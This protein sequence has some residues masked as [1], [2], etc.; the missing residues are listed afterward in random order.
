VKWVWEQGVGIRSAQGALLHLEGFITDIT[1]EMEAKVEL[2]EALRQKEFLMRELNHRVKNNLNMVSSLIN[3][4]DAESRDDLADIRAQINA[5][6]IIH[7][8]LNRTENLSEIRVRPY[9][10]E[11][12]DTVFTTFS[13]RTVTVENRVEDTVIKPE[14]ALPL[15]LIT[16]EAATNAIKHG[17]R[18]DEEALFTVEFTTLDDRLYEL[19]LS[20]SGNPFPEEIDIERA[21]TL[22][23][24][25]LR[26][27]AQQLDGSVE[28][29]KAPSP[30][31]TIRFPLETG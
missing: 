1:E 29:R 13:A 4:K 27:L 20:N 28:L 25:L 9:L 6:R 24:Q 26:T 12:L 19:R 16:N 2:E 15:G 30:M 22:G 17:F 11:L 21:E 10:E 14:V 3:L 5:I 31:F 8:K 18:E 23:L 7:E